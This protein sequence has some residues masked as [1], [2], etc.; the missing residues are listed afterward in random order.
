MGTDVSSGPGFLSKTRGGLAVV[1]SGLIF[2]KKKKKDS[3][4]PVYRMNFREQ[5][6]K[7]SHL[8]GSWCNPCVKVIIGK[9][10]DGENWL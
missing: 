7:K 1:S 8:G 10:G 6:G 5:D 2:L 4:A 3:L 9:G